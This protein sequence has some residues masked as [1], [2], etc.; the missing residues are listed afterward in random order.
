VPPYIYRHVQFVMRLFFNESTSFW[1][2]RCV[3]GAV[4]PNSRLN[5]EPSGRP[6]WCLINTSSSSH[7]ASVTWSQSRDQTLLLL[8]QTGNSLLITIIRLIATTLC[9]T[10]SL[11]LSAV[12]NCWSGQFF[13]Q[14]PNTVIREALF[15]S[16]IFR[17]VFSRHCFTL[18]LYVKVQNCMAIFW[19]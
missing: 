17:V 7:T 2:E 15:I 14:Q 3:A 6:V 4:K 10:R 16:N 1:C 18:H 11:L 9:Q 12:S 5:T 13:G 19:V 8:R